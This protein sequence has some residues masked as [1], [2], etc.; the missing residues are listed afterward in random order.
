MSPTPPATA[1]ETGIF[2]R[3]PHSSLRSYEEVHGRVNADEDLEGEGEECETESDSDAA[4]EVPPVRDALT[5]SDSRK[6][7]TAVRD[8]RR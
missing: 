2:A 6:D 8:R 5:G 3:F 1:W 7:D 4:V